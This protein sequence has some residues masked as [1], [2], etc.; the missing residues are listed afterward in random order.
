MPDLYYL[1]HNL[2]ELID[3]NC[4]QCLTSFDVFVQDWG[5]VCFDQLVADVHVEVQVIGQCH[6]LG[7]F[8][9]ISAL[10]RVP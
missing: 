4:F 9:V 10:L 8:K 2:G 1:E 6:K 7:E 3:T 5:F